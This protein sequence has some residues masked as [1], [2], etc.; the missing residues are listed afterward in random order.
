MPLEGDFVE[1]FHFPLE[2]QAKDLMRSRPDRFGDP[3]QPSIATTHE[4][5]I[6][7]SFR[8]RRYNRLSGERPACRPL[9]CHRRGRP[10]CVLRTVPEIRTALG[11]RGIS[12]VGSDCSVAARA[13]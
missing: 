8:A 13:V 10:G 5:S 7:Y 12:A 4:S 1:T 3:G 9:G 2:L 6:P 11:D